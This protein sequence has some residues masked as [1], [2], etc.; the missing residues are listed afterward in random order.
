MAEIL[1]NVGEK[2]KAIV[3]LPGEIPHISH[4]HVYFQD[5][6][7]EK[8]YGFGTSFWKKLINY[9]YFQL[10]LFELTNLEELQ[11]FIKR[12][13]FYVSVFTMSLVHLVNIFFTCSLPKV[14]GLS[15]CSTVL[16]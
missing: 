5:S 11:I 13:L 7:T 12:F 15:S 2:T 4:S 1:W 8:V 9:S 3:T 6:V 16:F 14:Q 10:Y